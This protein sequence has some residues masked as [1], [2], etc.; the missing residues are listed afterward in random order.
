MRIP[1]W[2]VALIAVTLAVAALILRSIPYGLILPLIVGWLVGRFVSAPSHPAR[3]KQVVVMATVWATAL[4]PISGF[5]AVPAQLMLVG[6]GIYVILA[7][8]QYPH[9]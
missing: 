3:S 1:L 2:G 8:V 6:I 9:D 4:G 7:E 5:I